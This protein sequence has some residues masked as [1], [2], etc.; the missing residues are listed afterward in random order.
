MI[1]PGGQ[2]PGG[3][4]PQKP[5]THV[6][7]TYP[8]AH[9]LR[10]DGTPPKD[11]RHTSSASTP[12]RF[13]AFPSSGVMLV[14]PCNVTAVN[15]LRGY[16]LSLVLGSYLCSVVALEHG[17]ALGTRGTPPPAAPAPKPHP[18]ASPESLLG[19]S[20]SP[21]G[22]R[23]ATPPPSHPIGFMVGNNAIL[24]KEILIWLFL[25]PIL[26]DFWVPSHP[27]PPFKQNSEQRW[28][29]CHLVCSSE[30]RP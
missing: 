17:T 29:I 19:N 22:G 16:C 14:Q 12:R 8:L 7:P 6:H 3:S 21:A 20:A 9:S 2:P 1:S 25:V 13:D 5:N 23:G 27:P 18:S 26:L 28:D 11:H 4:P 24:Q 10:V 30:R 15:W